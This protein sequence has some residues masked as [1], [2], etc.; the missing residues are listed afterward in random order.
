M[1]RKCDSNTKYF[2]QEGVNLESAQVGGALVKSSN[3]PTGSTKRGKHLDQKIDG[4]IFNTDPFVWSQKLSTR[5]I[6]GAM[7]GPT[8]NQG[9]RR[10]APIALARVRCQGSQYGICDGQSGHGTFLCQ[11][12]RS[13][14]SQCHFVQ[15]KSHI[16]CPGHEFEPPRGKTDS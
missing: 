6:S 5:A 4:Q 11:C 8:M 15:H 1:E 3:E 13:V 7:L 16:L 10:R 12:L 9:A 2:I 14:L